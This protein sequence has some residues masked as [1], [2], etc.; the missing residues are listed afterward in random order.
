MD[1]K[2]IWLQWFWN[3]DRKSSGANTSCSAVKSEIVPNKGLVKE[4]HKPINVKFEKQKVHSSFICRIWGA[5]LAYIQLISKFNKGT[6]FLLCLISILSKYAWV[7]PLK[8]K[9]V[10]QLIMLLDESNRKPNKI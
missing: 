6:C 9:K 4:L 2:E 7:I 3:C 5:D 1:I 10:L 8:E